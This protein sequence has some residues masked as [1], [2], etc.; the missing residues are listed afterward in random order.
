MKKNNFWKV[1]PSGYVS[2][3]ALSLIAFSDSSLT[4]I[5]AFILVFFEIS[6]GYF[7]QKNSLNKNIQYTDSM[8]KIDQLAAEL[9]QNKSTINSL[10][11]IGSQCLPIWTKQID[12]CIEIS[13]HEMNEL[14]QRFASIVNDLR[15][16]V[17][18]KGDDELSTA[19]IEERLDS[20]SKTF[21]KLL[22]MR[23]KSQEQ[24]IELSNFTEKLEIMARDV[25]GIA[26]QTNLL[27]LNAAIEAARAGESGR[28]FAVVAD[29]VRN[30]AN[31][32]GEIAANIIASVT[33]VNTQFNQISRNF[34]I[35][36]ENGNKLTEIA[37]ENIHAVIRQYNETKDARDKHAD[38]LEQLSS[39]VGKEIENT[40][41]SIQFQDR[42]SQILDHV[43][44]NLAQLSEQIEDHDNLNI[45]MLLDQM[46]ANYTT[47][48]ERE[49][50]RKLTGQEATTDSE[51]E[52]D[53]GEVVFF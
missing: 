4:L 41:V 23:V 7:K 19:Q 10:K 29:E 17:D 14:A 15:S 16:I 34:S 46:A 13:T 2:L 51:Q 38:N 45:Q 36:S 50:H 21:T 44:G 52:S 48:S 26:D 5:L 31:R 1:I 18:E 39:H 35:D 43:K 47:T 8:S 11:A 9:Q 53:D 20:T 24:I 40:L 49:V 12:D 6:L 30:L 33:N 37:D 32:S 25:G 3:F 22:E 28:G 42:I 27:A